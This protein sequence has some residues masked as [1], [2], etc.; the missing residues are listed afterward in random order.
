MGIKQALN[1]KRPCPLRAFILVE[2]LASTSRPTASQVVTSAHRGIEREG[3]GRNGMTGARMR[4]RPC[5]DPGVGVSAKVLCSQGLG[6]LA[7]EVG[8]AHLDLRKEVGIRKIING[9]SSG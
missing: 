7:V 8:M 6:S 4:V 5:L 3:L 1:I 9:A 2:S